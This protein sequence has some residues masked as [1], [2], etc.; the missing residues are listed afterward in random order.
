MVVYISP[1][2][3]LHLL[4]PLHLS[5]GSCQEDT[6]C[7]VFVCHLL[8]I[9]FIVMFKEDHLP[10]HSQTRPTYYSGTSI[11]RLVAKDRR[12]MFASRCNRRSF[13]ISR[14][15]PCIFLFLPA[16][17]YYTVFILKLCLLLLF[18]LKQ[19]TLPKCKRDGCIPML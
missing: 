15:F 2:N 14:F 3:E 10:R 11:K 6:F 16:D 13:V 7:D 18:I 1:P 19:Q 4:K 9:S 8:Y 12:N 5:L 17:I